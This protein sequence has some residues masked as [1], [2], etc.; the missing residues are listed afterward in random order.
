MSSWHEDGETLASGI[1][2]SLLRIIP[3]T[4]PWNDAS[5]MLSIDGKNEPE[6]DDI[7][8]GRP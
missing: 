3:G 1:Q 4:G 2:N 7:D 6:I 5:I 8:G